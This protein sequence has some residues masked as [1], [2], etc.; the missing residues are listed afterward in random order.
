MEYYLAIKR[1]ILLQHTMNTPYKYITQ[2][3][4]KKVVLYK[5]KLIYRARNE[6]G[7]GRDD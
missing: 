5:A 3:K 2:K 4:Y 1:N 6:N 7:D